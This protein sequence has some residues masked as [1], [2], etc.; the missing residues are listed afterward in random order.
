MAEGLNKT[1]RGLNPRYTLF[2][3]LATTVDADSAD[4]QKVLK[5]ASTA[6]FA[7]GDV[8]EIDSAG[9]GGGAETGTIASI[10]AGVSL[11]LEDSLSNAHAA[12]DADIVIRQGKYMDVAEGGSDGDGNAGVHR[13]GKKT[14]TIKAASVTDGNG[15]TVE[16]YGKINGEETLIHSDSIVLAADNGTYYVHIGVAFDDIYCK[17][18]S[19]LD[20]TLT[21]KMSGTVGL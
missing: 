7:E 11:T 16:L 18:D 14:V 21:V 12:L 20:G 2:E 8:V 1:I 17:V 6:G 13:L 3:T 15:L 9:A 19:Y 10:Q 4:G 5:V